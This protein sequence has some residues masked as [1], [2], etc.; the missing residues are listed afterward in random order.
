[1]QKF[2][3]SSVAKNSEDW[4]EHKGGTI[5]GA[6]FTDPNRE[7]RTVPTQANITDFSISSRTL[8]ENI[9]YELSH[10]RYYGD[11]FPYYNFDCFGPGI[12]AAYLGAE[13]DNHS[14][15]VWF[16]AEPN[17]LETL[18]L[19]VDYA[20]KYYRRAVEIID[21]VY[22]LSKGEYIVGMPDL[23][24][25]I[26]VY[27]TFRHG[28]EMFYDMADDPDNMVR[29]LDRIRDAWHEVYDK[30][31]EHYKKQKGYSDWSRIYSS[32][33]SYVIQADACFMFGGEHFDKFVLPYVKYQ[34]EHIAR[35]VYHLDGKGELI[36]LDKLLALPGLNAIQWI[37][38]AGE[39]NIEWTDLYKKILQ[40]GKS[41]QLP[42]CSLDEAETIIHNIGTAKNVCAFPMWYSIDEMDSVVKRLEKLRA[43]K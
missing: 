32:V 4:W 20:N 38:G 42:Y 26:D 11:A 31:N 40:S 2:D 12:L 15:S 36:H 27:S 7:Y 5:L 43:L 30:L 16:M 39:N 17:E 28:E 33:P 22:D 6:V 25:I 1:M 10:N 19:T 9:V 23:G 37:P 3:Y 8:A 13:V 41:L 24:G 35:T 34:T 18:H 29:V 21:Y 14:G